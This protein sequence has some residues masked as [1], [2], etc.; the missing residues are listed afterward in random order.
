MPP[1][2]L[3]IHHAELRRLY[4]YWMAK[5]GDLVAPPRSAIEPVEIRSILPRLLLID[6]IGDPPRFRVRLAGTDVAYHY[7]AE[8]TGKFVDELDL[9]EIGHIALAEYRD[10]TRLRQ[11]MVHQWEYTKHDGRHLKYE[12]LILPLSS[13]GQAVDMLLCGVAVDSSFQA[14]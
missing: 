8:I 12:R 10:A 5:K 6:V 13:D 11:P 1:P 14:S 7:G 2:S 9:D 4:D 3:V